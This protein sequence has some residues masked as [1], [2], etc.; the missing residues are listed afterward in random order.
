MGQNTKEEYCLGDKVFIRVK[1]TDFEKKHID[2]K[3]ISKQ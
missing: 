1:K 2:F 3:I